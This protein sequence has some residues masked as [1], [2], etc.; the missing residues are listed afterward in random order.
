LGGKRNTRTEKVILENIERN[1]WNKRATSMYSSE[2][3]QHDIGEWIQR[4]LKKNSLSRQ[5]IKL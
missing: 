1:I 4:N 3:E 2:K 5:F